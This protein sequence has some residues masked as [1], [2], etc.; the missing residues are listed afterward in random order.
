M[1]FTSYVDIFHGCGGM[2]L[3]EPVGVAATWFPIKAITGNT[4]PAA[5]LLVSFSGVFTFNNNGK[6]ISG[7]WSTKKRLRKEA[8]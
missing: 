5:C 3:P 2:D 7:L 4:N 6:R 1:K 8:W